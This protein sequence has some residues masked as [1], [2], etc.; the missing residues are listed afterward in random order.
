MHT[1]S[2]IEQA[3]I[4]CKNCRL[5]Q[6][7]FLAVPGVGVENAD[8]FV[9]AEAPGLAES[10]PKQYPGKTG[11][12]LVGPAGTKLQDTLVEAG[13]SKHSFF[14]TNVVKH[15]PPGN[16][17][18]FADEKIACSKYLLAQILAVKP[19]MILALGR[20]AVDTIAILGN[21][22]LGR[23][24]NSADYLFKHEWGDYPLHTLEIPV[25]G[26][27]HPSYIL[28]NPTQYSTWYSRLCRI[29]TQLE[30]LCK[31]KTS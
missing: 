17:D 31:P 15:R 14:V 28:R 29:Q 27:F 1:L 8:L 19:K 10:D 4:S 5:F 22:P 7:P 16:R 24:I 2:S 11:V 23:S 6:E 9:C 30:E 21:A 25:Y 3:V 26:A 12:P 20:H 18:P 13:F